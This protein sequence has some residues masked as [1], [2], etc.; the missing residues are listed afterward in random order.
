VPR[1]TI[2]SAIFLPGD[3]F[4]RTVEAVLPGVLP[5]GG[6]LAVLL[7]KPDHGKMI[8]DVMLHL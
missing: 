7:R 8:G 6:F 4:A 5:W 1:V 2:R 3:A